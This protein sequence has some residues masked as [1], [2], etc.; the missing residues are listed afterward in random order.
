[1]IQ[2]NRRG[3][4]GASGAGEKKFVS[5]SNFVEWYKGAK[6]CVLVDVECTEI[7]S[8]DTIKSLGNNN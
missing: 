6:H 8:E 2:L 5:A 4:P 3:A 7:T 1:L